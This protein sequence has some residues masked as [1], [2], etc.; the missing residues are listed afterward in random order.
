MQ[1]L[2]KK[3]A[4]GLRKYGILT[5][6][7]LSSGGARMWAIDGREVSRLT[8]WIHPKPFSRM[9]AR[10]FGRRR[11]VVEEEYIDHNRCAAIF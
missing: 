8:K 11:R 1:M 5:R 7:L 6:L 10:E 4:R 3:S 2:Y 9:P